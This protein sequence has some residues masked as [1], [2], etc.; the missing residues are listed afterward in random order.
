[1]SFQFVHIEA[2]G[3]VN[4]KGGRTTGYVLDEADRK[5]DACPHIE[6][7]Q[8]PS[9]VFGKSVDEVRT[10][11]DAACEGAMTTL[12]NGKTRHIKSDQHTLMTVIASHPAK[13]AE[14]EADPAVKA[15]VDAW[16]ERNIAWMK[17]R[18]GDDLVSVIRHDDESH[19]HLHAYV[20]P[21]SNPEL[22]ASRLHPGAV[23]KSAEMQCGIDDC[24]D[25]KENNKLGDR[26]YREAMRSFQD[27][28][29]E[30]VGLPCGLT[31]IG[32]GRRRLDRVDYMAE[33]TLVKTAAIAISKAEQATEKVSKIS[34][35]MAKA[36]G[37]WAGVKTGMQVLE[38]EKARIERERQRLL[39]EKSAA[40][41]ERDA[42][43]L[44]AKRLA[45]E[46]VNKAKV[47]VDRISKVSKSIGSKL[48]WFLDATKNAGKT[49]EKRILDEKVKS[50][51]EGSKDGFDGREPEVKTLTEANK[52]VTNTLEEERRRISKLEAERQQLKEGKRALEMVNST[53][54]TELT[55]AT[56]QAETYRV[57]WTD[58]DNKLQNLGQ[59]AG[60]KNKR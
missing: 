19:I 24:R 30:K 50:H 14:A 4:S 32:P 21:T 43:L 9:V 46:M 34:A 18:W 39:Q 52:T 44:D 7:P 55:R 59:S 12:R 22:R 17:E 10:L 27:D 28:Y 36:K 38:K 13:S 57:K 26:A 1:M 8:P 51:A 56:N 23:A 3:K 16:Q 58:T 2:F 29:W 45:R 42:I 6:K 53:L 49:I 11:H 35:Y 31:R 37:T 25:K 54:K 41:K 60:S 48:G 15:D 40:I 33:K 47:E 5:P 20:L